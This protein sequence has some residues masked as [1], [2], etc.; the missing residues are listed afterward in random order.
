[1]FFA[2]DNGGPAAPEVMDAMMRANEGTAMP[3]GA[4]PIMDRVRAQIR[5]V[6]EAPEAEV[7]LVATGTAANSISLAC[8]VQPWQ[9]VYCHRHAHIEADECGAPEFYTGGSKLTLIDGADGKMPA[10]ALKTAISE[11][12]AVG[13]HGVQKGALSITNATESGTVYTPAEVAELAG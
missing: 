7:Y 11:T 3:Y 1:M 4:D 13:V 5:E 12:G 9:T 10:A 8:L 6:F 2:S